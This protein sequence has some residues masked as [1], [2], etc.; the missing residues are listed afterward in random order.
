MKII[1]VKIQLVI[2]IAQDAQVQQFAPD[3][4][5]RIQTKEIYKM[6][7]FV[8]LQL[9]VM[10]VYAQVKYFYYILY[11]VKNKFCI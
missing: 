4:R 5:N 10:E 11:N 1:F 6:H 8:N 3:V 2:I 9:G 7:V